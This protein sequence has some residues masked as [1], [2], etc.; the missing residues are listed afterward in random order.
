MPTWIQISSSEYEEG[1]SKLYFCWD[2][3]QNNKPCLYVRVSLYVK[4]FVRTYK[5]TEIFVSLY[6]YVPAS[7]NFSK[8]VRTYRLPEIWRND[9]QIGYEICTW[10]FEIHIPSSGIT[11][12]KEGVKNSN[13]DFTNRLI[14][15]VDPPPPL[16][17]EVQKKQWKSDIFLTH[18]WEGALFEEGW[19]GF[20]TLPNVGVAAVFWQFT[21]HCGELM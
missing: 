11:L 8:F 3:L 15:R 7:W 21:S 17:S 6:V 10:R 19:G 1:R 16:R 13:A 12:N 14:T 18:I 9:F 2:F 4:K 5:L 20:S